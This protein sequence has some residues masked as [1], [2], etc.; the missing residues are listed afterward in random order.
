MA[1]KM[2]NGSLTSAN[3]ISGFM[4][5]LISYRCHKKVEVRGALLY[6]LRVTGGPTYVLKTDHRSIERGGNGH[7]QYLHIF[8]K[9][10]GIPLRLTFIVQGKTQIEP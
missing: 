9:F 6:Y 2:L 7:H 3:I 4:Q 1:P 8:L 10:Q 5:L